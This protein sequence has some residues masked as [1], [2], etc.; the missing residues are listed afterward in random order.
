MWF[1]LHLELFAYKANRKVQ[2]FF[3]RHW[4]RE[5]WKTDAFLISWFSFSILHSPG[6]ENLGQ[7]I[8]HF[9]NIPLLLLLTLFFQWNLCYTSTRAQN[10]SPHIFVWENI[11][12]IFFLRLICGLHV[13]IVNINWIHWSDLHFRYNLKVTYIHI[14]VL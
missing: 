13:V 8:G 14:L 2:T 7:Q 5:T 10:L 1:T 9:I 4:Q 12:V 11:V 3:S 6:Q